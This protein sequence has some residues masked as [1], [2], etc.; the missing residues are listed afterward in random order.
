MSPCHAAMCVMVKSTYVIPII[1]V[2]L[3]KLY[4]SHISNF[5]LLYTDNKYSSSTNTIT[6]Q[7]RRSF[8]S[9]FETTRLWI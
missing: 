3:A 5:T 1:N 6:E 4:I 7:D 2:V 8:F 9:Y